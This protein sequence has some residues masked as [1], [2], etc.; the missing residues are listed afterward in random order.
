MIK[1]L[2]IT[3]LFAPHIRGGFEQECVSAR[4][5]WRAL[6]WQV[7]ILTEARRGDPAPEPGVHRLLP[8]EPVPR[9]E[10]RR[11]D[12]RVA[13]W[14]VRSAMVT[15]RLL[16]R[17]RPDIVVTWGS[18]GI[19]RGALARAHRLPSIGLAYDY[20]LRDHVVRERDRR[21]RGPLGHALQALRRAAGITPA[22]LAPRSWV[23]CSRFVRNAHEQDMGPLDG[24]VIYHGVEV[25]PAPP[26]LATTAGDRLV[27]GAGARLAPEKGL[28][29]V[30]EAAVRLAEHDAARR[31]RFEIRG[32]PSDPEYAG[33]LETQAAEAR[34]HG[35][36]VEILPMLP[37]GEYRR[38]LATLDVLVVPAE[39]DE[40][41]ALVPLEGMA[42]GRVVV[43]NARGGAAELLVDGVNSLVT[44]SGDAA[45]LAAA[46]DRLQRDR[47]LV[48]RLAMGGH[49]HVAAGF[50]AEDMARAL[51]EHVAAR[52]ARGATRHAAA[53]A[54]A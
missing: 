7:D 42:A 39:W 26:P 37:H 13:L 22:A 31:P 43:G 30:V 28:H 14:D 6:G 19:S 21:W 46:L 4:D 48:E 51:A 36:E 25:P 17:L 35:A 11:D 24:D 41:F 29:T 12:I 20:C 33:R 32:F 52:A 50:R 10:G 38:W 44:P 9:G 18:F 40:P 8:P 16:R 34:R 5:H 47:A 1:V 2:S 3:N 27:V 15:S 45:A 23:F 49:R 54:R 53:P